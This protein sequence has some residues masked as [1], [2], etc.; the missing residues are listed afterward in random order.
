MTAL[1]TTL[2]ASRDNSEVIRDEIAA[3]LA[4]EQA[5]QQSLATAAS[6]DPRLWELR[7][8]TERSNPWA[9][10]RDPEAD[11]LDNPPIVNVV[12]DG[13]TYDP[14]ASNIVGR[15]KAVATYNIDCYGL[16]VAQD[17]GNGGH[18][19]GDQEAAETVQR[20]VRL[21]RNILMAGTYVTLGTGLKGKVW[22][23]WLGSVSMFQPQ[24]EDRA[25]QNVV[26]AR[27]AFQVEFNEFSPPVAEETLE[28]V[29]NTINRSETGEVYAETLHDYS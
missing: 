28:L 22:K 6:E 17:D 7:V 4:V 13:I 14:S 27:L 5:N 8:F 2:I 3:I 12:L 25:M 24:S 10:F 9:S 18:L 15:Q 19:A 26:A 1:I 29:Q 23:R 21:V 11:P 20:A 16:G